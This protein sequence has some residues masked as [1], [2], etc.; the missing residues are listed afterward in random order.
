[1]ADNVPK[2]NNLVVRVR[3]IVGDIVTGGD[4]GVI[5]ATDGKVFSAAAVNARLNEAFAWIV[6]QLV[7]R[8]GV[9]AA[10]IMLSDSIVQQAFTI[11][12]SGTQVQYDYL[13][14]V[15]LIYA[16]NVYAY[17]TK[18]DLDA[19]FDP[20]LDYGFAIDGGKIYVYKRTTGTLTILSSGSAAL[21]YLKSDGID[22]STGS[23][24]APNTTPDITLNVRWYEPCLLY[25]AWRLCAD[26]GDASWLDMAK[27]FKAQAESFLPQVS[28]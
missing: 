27:D 21:F 14:Q 13:Y 18:N 4:N 28:Q 26:K 17:R 5:A 7:Q 16:T 20:Y 15:R 3:N 11:S 25:A 9:E 22:P 6:N 12:S 2:K 19:D 10:K 1:M 23:D 24:L 8:V